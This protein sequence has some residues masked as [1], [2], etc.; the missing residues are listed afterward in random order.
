MRFSKVIVGLFVFTSTFL[1][2]SAQTTPSISSTPISAPASDQQIVVLATVNIYNVTSAQQGDT[3]TVSFDITNRVGVQPGVKYGL[4][5]VKETPTGQ[6]VVDEHIYDEVLSLGENSSIHKVVT[7]QAPIYLEGDYKLFISSQNKNGF[8][9][10]TGF[11]GTVA[12]TK[13]SSLS[14]NIHQDTCYLTVEGE[15][16]GKKYIPMQGVDIAPTEVLLSN[17]IVENTSD[18]QVTA[19][20]SFVTR[21]R[22][23]FGDVVATTGGDTAPTSIAPHEKKMIVTKLSQATTPQSYNVELRYGQESNEI[24]YH[25]VIQGG[26]GTIQNVLFDK[27]SYMKG[28]TARVS[29]MWTPSTDNFSDSRKGTGTQL[30]APSFTIMVSDEQGKKCSTSTTHPLIENEIL[31]KVDMVF[32]QNCLYS[33]ADIVITDAKLGILAHSVF[34]ISTTTSTIKIPAT[35]ITNFLKKESKVTFGFSFFFIFLILIS[36]YFYKKINS[37]KI[38]LKPTSIVLLIGFFFT[39]ISS[40]K[41]E[42]FSF[43]FS[44]GDTPIVV[45]VSSDKDTYYLG[46]QMIV[47]WCPYSSF[48]CSNPYSATIVAGGPVVLVDQGYTGIS[49]VILYLATPK[50]IGVVHVTL[51]F[52]AVSNGG[53]SRVIY[54]VINFTQQ[55]PTVNLWFSLLQK[56][57]NSLGIVLVTMK[58]VT[59]IDSAFAE[60]K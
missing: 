48:M 32:S 42:T 39:S 25:Y 13:S 53:A 1:S 11:A 29:F 2:V 47:S 60:S 16:G 34:D 58:N 15:Q 9:F 50:I 8:P 28:E 7:Y 18:S 14:L 59:G 19:I 43:K 12:L 54:H 17:C 26:S 33:K 21:S 37:P 44:Q 30:T 36:L 5:L 40:V 45:T 27:D 46:E 6:V 24:A 55:T 20:P 57:Q 52:I 4:S 10:G 41:A 56:F 38:S 23:H 3:V 22:S 49:G 31:V 51:Q 35:T